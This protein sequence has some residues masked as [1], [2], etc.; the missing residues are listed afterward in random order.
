M[1]SSTWNGENRVLPCNCESRS[2]N[3]HRRANEPRF[4]LGINN[5]PANI[6]KTVFPMLRRKI[7]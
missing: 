4:N 7:L 2:E 5:T 1:H 6:K 3:L